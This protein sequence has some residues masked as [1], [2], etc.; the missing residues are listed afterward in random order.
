MGGVHTYRVS[1]MLAEGRVMRAVLRQWSIKQEVAV[2]QRLFVQRWC[3]A[4]RVFARH[5]VGPRR[6]AEQPLRPRR[7]AEQG[8]GDGWSIEEWPGTALHT[9]PPPHASG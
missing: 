4:C 2:E 6:L 5:G 7:L 1:A 8:R 9:V 3:A